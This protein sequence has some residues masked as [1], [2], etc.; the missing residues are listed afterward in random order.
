MLVTI[1]YQS[2]VKIIS[3]RLA[4]ILI[5]GCQRKQMSR[6]RFVTKWAKSITVYH[7]VCNALMR[8]AFNAK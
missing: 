7:Y 6:I 3:L 5:S 8:T 2:D 1:K 4:G